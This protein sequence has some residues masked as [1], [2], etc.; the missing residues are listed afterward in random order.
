[1]AVAAVCTSA[2]LAAAEW[3]W[4]WPA[5]ATGG[6][7]PQVEITPYLYGKQW[8]YTVEIDD[9]PK[10]THD[11]AMPLLARQQFTDAPPGVSA[12][13]LMPFVGGAAIIVLRVGGN[14][15]HLS[16]DDCRALRDAGW[17]IINHSYFHRGRLGENGDKL[18]PEDIRFDLFW[19]Q[20]LIAHEVGDGRAATHFAYPYGNSV[21]QKYLGEFGMVSGSRT[22]GK[23]IRHPYNDG[24][25]HLDYPRNN[26]DEKA[27]S[28]SRGNS[29][30]LWQF[31]DGDGPA[32]GQ[33]VLDFTHAIEPPGTQN[34]KRWEK[35]LEFI[36]RT[37]G[38]AG[39]D[40][41]WSASNN[42][43]FSYVKARQQANVVVDAEGVR[44]S[45]PDGAP[46]SRLTLKITG[47]DPGADLPTPDGALVYRQGNTVWV[48]TPV[49]GEAGAAIPQPRVRRVYKG[50]MQSVQFDHPVQVAAVRLHQTGDP[51][52]GFV[53]RVDAQLADGS[54][55][56][57]LPEMVDLR[58]GNGVWRLYGPV[59]NAPA[60]T[61]TAVEVNHDQC[62]REME[63]W[64]LD[65][66]M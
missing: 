8:A 36:G 3:S 34:N 63:I 65:T 2:S 13:R 15:H 66:G 40:N 24:A 37:F 57:L 23:S 27:W 14:E 52:E 18:S 45:L 48:T 64:A 30:V 32:E 50:P 28:G 7:V 62:F 29:E 12:G 51:S 10:L 9:A 44:V 1:M 58:W 47:I 55:R 6:A 31:P 60:V 11:V 22:A 53:L 46:G 54:S 41:V 43:I 56:S 21:Y 39:K 49:I 16:W 17:G 35:R 19:S 4:Q 26:I 61:A 38:A 20:T 33:L 59:P 5:G 42:E 25:I